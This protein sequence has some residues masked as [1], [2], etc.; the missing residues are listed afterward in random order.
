MA[1]LTEHPAWKELQAESRRAGEW[2][3]RDLFA[4]D[5]ARETHYMRTAGPLTLDFSRERLTAGALQLL[6][7]LAEEAK[8]RDARDA[9]FAGRI[10]NPSE[11]RAARHP[12]L[13]GPVKVDSI[14]ES[15]A[16]M[17][18][19]AEDL[20][21]GKV[22]GATGKTIRNLVHVGI[23]GSDVG[24]RLLE[25]VL[26]DGR[27]PRLRFLANA[28]AASLRAATRGLASD[29]TLVM[30]ASKSFGTA[31]MLRN[32]QSLRE[33]L[34]VALGPKAGAHLLAATAA[35]A[36]AKAFGVAEDRILPLD[37]AVGGRFSL[38]SAVS[39]AAACAMGRENFEALLSGAAEMDAHAAAA[40]AET[41]LPLISALTGI[42]NI[43]LLGFTSRALLPYAEPL[44]LL[45][46]Y[47]QQLEM[48]SLGKSVSSEGRALD[49]ATAPVVFGATGTP[50]QHAF[51][52][53]LH[54]GTSVMPAE[55][56]LAGQ[57]DGPA[58]HRALMQAN[59][60]AQAEAL[61]FG[62]DGGTGPLAAQKKCGGNRPSSILLLERLDARALG[63]LIAFYEHRVFLQGLLWGVNP[64]DQ[65][66]VELGKKLAAPLQAVLEG[67]KDSPPARVPALLQRLGGKGREGHKGP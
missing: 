31:E 48:E 47:L 13:R 5:P 42:W 17:L 26:A 44:A 6:R 29:E 61:A 51:M 37:E 53:A 3:L 55:I 60:L 32:G 49:Y 46:L 21:A 20:R 25:A 56:I 38:W 57:D 27:G 52:Q 22:K 24:P 33:W 7:D 10:V 14:A 58:A 19:L 23:G 28:D 11:N 1:L 4:A 67:R 39:L 9:L 65:W 54:Q 50:A 41:N 2:H 16:K 8:W 12:A 43:N 30:L 34:A 35:P 59:A 40:P 66:G 18:E 62:A 36:K 45:P 64:F 63:A 15:Q